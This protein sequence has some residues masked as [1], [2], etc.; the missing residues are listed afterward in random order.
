LIALQLRHQRDAFTLGFGLLDAHHAVDQFLKVRFAA[1]QRDFAALKS[2]HVEQVLDQ[3]RHAVRNLIQNLDVLLG[4]FWL[5]LEEIEARLD[6]GERRPQF[7]GSVGDKPHALL[8][9]GFLLADVAD[10]GHRADDLPQSIPH[11]GGGQGGVKPTV[12]GAL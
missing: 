1:V 10:Y 9:Q 6:V 3:F 4:L 7:V 8:L 11:T 12:V 5:A 2:R